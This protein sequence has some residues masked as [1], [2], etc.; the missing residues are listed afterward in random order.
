MAMILTKDFVLYLDWGLHISLLK[1]QIVNILGFAGHKV[2]VAGLQSAF[3]IGKR[4]Q[5]I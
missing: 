3:V 4:S 1:D 2:S 5:A